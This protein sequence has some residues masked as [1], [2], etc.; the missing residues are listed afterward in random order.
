MTTYTS[1]AQSNHDYFWAHVAAHLTMLHGAISD[2]VLPYSQYAFNAPAWSLSLEWQFYLV[3]PLAVMLAGR[4]RTIV[5]VALA[6]TALEITYK[7]DLLGSFRLP[8]F[9]PGAVGFFAVGIA[10]R[11]VLPKILNSVRHPNIIWAL[12]IVLIPVGWAVLPIAVWAIVLTG[13]ALA[14]SDGGSSLFVRAYRAALESRIATYFG[15]RSYSIYLCHLPVVSVCLA[16]WLRMDPDALQVATFF[17]VSAMAIPLTI[18]VAEFLY[19]GIERPG[20]ALGSRL[21]RR[22]KFVATAA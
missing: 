2:S 11:L 3:A 20:I 17:G 12:L 18:L 21:A 6:A 9:L 1:I 7:F 22:R 10:S 5:W 4:P 15:S 14:P 13:L 16:I 8:S 19:R